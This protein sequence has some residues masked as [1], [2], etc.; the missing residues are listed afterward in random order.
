MLLNLHRLANFRFSRFSLRAFRAR[1]RF[2]PWE[3]RIVVPLRRA[4]LIDRIALLSDPFWHTTRVFPRGFARSDDARLLAFGTL[5][6]A[7]GLTPRSGAGFGQYEL[8]ST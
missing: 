4:E 3:G 6:P 1:I 5:P 8:R 2:V 7:A